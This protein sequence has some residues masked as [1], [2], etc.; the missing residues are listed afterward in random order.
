MAVRPFAQN[1]TSCIY[2]QTNSYEF[3]NTCTNQGNSS[4]TTIE[5]VETNKK[6]V[7][8]NIIDIEARLTRLEEAESKSR[9]K[10]VQNYKICQNY[11]QRSAS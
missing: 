8:E 5:Q 3:L 6:A 11:Y 4:Q 1:G 9:M 2:C 10:T 7:E